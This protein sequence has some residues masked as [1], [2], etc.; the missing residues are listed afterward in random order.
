MRARDVDVCLLFNEPNIRYA[1]GVSAMPI[2]SNTTF[3]RAALV[4]ADGAPILFEHGNSIHRSR[5]VVEDVRPDACVGVLRRRRGG[6][7]DL[8]T[9]DR[10]RTW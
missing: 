7:R 1:T 9:R 4:P 6:G 3:V 5:L 10:V 2:W 8:G